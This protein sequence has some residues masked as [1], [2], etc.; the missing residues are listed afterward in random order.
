MLILTRKSDESIV[1]SNNIVVKV[2]RVHGNQVHLGITAPREV[3]V[4]RHEIYEQIRQENR[5]AAQTAPSP[6]DM[7]KLGAG[8]GQFRRLLDTTKRK[9]V[10]AVGK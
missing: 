4:Y 10:P 8:L 1:I 9:N 7:S 2:L 6:V 3:P 5:N